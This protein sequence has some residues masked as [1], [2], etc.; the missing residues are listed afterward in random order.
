MKGIVAMKCEK[1]GA[2]LPNN[3]IVCKKCGAV[4]ELP[5]P[6][7]INDEFEIETETITD[8]IVVDPDRPKSFQVNKALIYSIIFIVV[9]T[10]IFIYF[11]VDKNLANRPADINRPISVS[12]TGSADDTYS[13]LNDVQVQALTAKDWKNPHFSEKNKERA[14]DKMIYLIYESGVTSIYDQY[15]NDEI[16]MLIDSFV[17]NNSIGS[18]TIYER[19]LAEVTSSG[20]EELGYEM[21]NGFLKNLERYDWN[22]P[23]FTS[24]VKLSI[25]KNT[26]KMAYSEDRKE[27]YK[28]YSASDIVAL[29]DKYAKESVKDDTVTK[30]YDM[31]LIDAA[32]RVE[33][34]VQ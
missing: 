15:K 13:G 17:S 4:V 12:S 1:C 6:D 22:N 28:Y 18:L 29:Y 3:A 31:L 25:A 9:S 32:S 20:T 19:L 7:I 34:S 26:I 10:S 27:V 8:I 33:K 16:M 11:Y 23:K 14:V 30:L 2:K 5:E 24:D 21:T